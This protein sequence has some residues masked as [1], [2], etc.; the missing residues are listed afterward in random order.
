MADNRF[1]SSRVASGTLNPGA[2]KLPE[3]SHQVPEESSAISRDDV[4]DGFGQ[5]DARNQR[6]VLA[7]STLSGDRVRNSAGESLGKI[8]EIML[9]IQ[10]GRIAYAVLSFGGF[11]GIGNKLFAVP[12]SALQIDTGEHEFILDVDRGTLENAPGFDKDDWPD[13]TDPDFVRDVSEYYG[14][15]P[16]WEHNFTDAGDYTGDNRQSNPTIEEPVSGFRPAGKH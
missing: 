12:W 8:E 5:E 3:I 9:D 13:M 15:T 10:T 4:R 16:F 1:E 14:K 7:A 11:L 6:H 2:Q